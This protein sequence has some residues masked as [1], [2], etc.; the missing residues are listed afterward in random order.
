MPAMAR[1]SSVQMCTTHN[2]RHRL[3]WSICHSGVQHFRLASFPPV[4]TPWQ[5]IFPNCMRPPLLVLLLLFLL[6]RFF[7]GSISF[8]WVLHIQSQWKTEHTQIHSMHVC[9]HKHIALHK[10]IHA[11]LWRYV[12]SQTIIRSL[13]VCKCYLID[14]MYIGNA[15]AHSDHHHCGSLAARIPIFCCFPQFFFLNRD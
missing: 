14:L 12:T 3:P 11:L 1:C 8:R 9:M 15:N 4:A 13:T 7:F 5:W 6:H 2:A 10:H